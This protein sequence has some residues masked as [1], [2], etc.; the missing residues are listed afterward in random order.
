MSKQKGASQKKGWMKTKKITLNKLDPSGKPLVES[1]TVEKFVEMYNTQNL[2]FTRTTEYTQLLLGQL[3][4]ENPNNP[5][6]KKCDTK[7]LGYA[8]KRAQEIKENPERGILVFE[9]PELEDEEGAADNV[10][11]LRPEGEPE[12]ET[13][14]EEETF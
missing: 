8:K 10:V 9:E 12:K 6:F 3:F 14:P 4:L 1:I 2:V 5:F 11:P 7:L 13:P